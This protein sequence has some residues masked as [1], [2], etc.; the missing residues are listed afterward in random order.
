MM[1][2]KILGILLSLSILSLAAGCSAS[3]TEPE[4]AV[5][6]G[7]EQAGTDVGELENKGEPGQEE[8]VVE[9]KE[10]DEKE[11]VTAEPENAQPENTQPENTQPGNASKIPLE[12][13]QPDENSTAII[14]YEFKKDYALDYAEVSGTLEFKIPQLTMRSVEAGKI[15]EDILEYFEEK[16]DDMDEMVEDDRDLWAEATLNIGYELTYLN[17]DK[18]CLLLTGYEYNGDAAHGIPFRKPLIYNLENGERMEAED[19]FAVSEDE[20]GRAFIAAFE[21]R[22]AESPDDYWTDA[23]DYVKEEASFD[24]EDFYLTENGVVF[25]FEPYVLAAYAYGYIEGEVSYDSLGLK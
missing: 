14:Y 6:A 20:F 11:E 12:N 23:M 15:N 24:N 7:E 4:K 22:M 10:A 2:K 19:L 16:L 21:K 25:Y 9:P 18:I 5:S 1:K 17:D 3:K 13:G 8:P